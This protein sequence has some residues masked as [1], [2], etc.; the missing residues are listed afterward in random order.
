MPNRIIKES[1]LTSETTASLDDFSFR[2]FVSL[3]CLADD[4]GRGKANPAII[5]GQAFALRDEVTKEQVERGL[6]ELVKVD[7]IHLYT[8]GDTTYFYFPTW[9]KHQR[10]R[11]SKA[12][13]PPPPIYD[14]LPQFAADCGN[15]PQLAADCRNLPPNPIPIENPNNN[16]TINPKMNPTIE[17]VETYVKEKQ[18]RIDPEKFFNYY[19]VR[20]W[21]I[22]STDIADWKALVNSWEKREKDKGINDPNHFDDLKDW[23]NLTRK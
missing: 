20:G 12:K 22:G 10:V 11:N 1:I 7:A 18:Y 14:N 16:P 9:S 13:C 19:S 3:I 4:F 23:V 6:E 8:I 5:K 17:Q 21:K 15:S 2:L